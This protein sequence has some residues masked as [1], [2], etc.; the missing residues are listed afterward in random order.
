MKNI[1]GYKKT[2]F[3]KY[4]NS[5]AEYDRI[6]ETKLILDNEGEFYKDYKN[7]QDKIYKTLLDGT[8]DKG[9]AVNGIQRLIYSYIKSGK[10]KYLP[11]LT[12]K[13]REEVAN[14]MLE[15]INL[16]LSSELPYFAKALKAKKKL[17]PS[18]QRRLNKILKS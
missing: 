18:M 17:T 12:K 6:F 9:K 3:D 8:Y 16:D 10:N 4:Y 5:N 7:M 14:A 2:N 1:L 15:D 13:E 11:V